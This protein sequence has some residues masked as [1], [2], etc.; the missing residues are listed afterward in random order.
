LPAKRS[1]LSIWLVI[2]VPATE[3]G[4]EGQLAEAR[5]GE[6]CTPPCSAPTNY[7]AS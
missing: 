3:A 6:G 5:G 2:R 7:T 4:V 1:R